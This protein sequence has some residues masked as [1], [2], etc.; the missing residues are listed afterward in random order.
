M[1]SH[2]LPLM[3]KCPTVNGYFQKDIIY[4]FI[5]LPVTVG[6]AQFKEIYGWSLKAYIFPMCTMFISCDFFSLCSK[7]LVDPSYIHEYGNFNIIL[8]L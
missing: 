5:V 6:T 1:D 2:K 7:H 3:S 8:F 4:S